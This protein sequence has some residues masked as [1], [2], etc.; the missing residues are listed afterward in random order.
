MERAMQTF[1][2][3]NRDWIDGPGHGASSGDRTPLTTY[4]DYVRQ[5]R[6]AV[7]VAVAVVVLIV[8]VVVCC[9]WRWWC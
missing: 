2:T 7:A 8:V 4:Q 3:D 6:G 1:M 9:W 5:V